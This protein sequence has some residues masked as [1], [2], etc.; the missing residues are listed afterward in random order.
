MD[1]CIKNDIGE[2]MLLNYACDKL[3]IIKENYEVEVVTVHS[4]QS[5]IK[6]L[7]EEC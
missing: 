4:L 3:T 7:N 5:M 2:Q 1:L 6:S